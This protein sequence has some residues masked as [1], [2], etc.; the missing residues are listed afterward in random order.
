MFP[1]L[2]PSILQHRGEGEKM[3]TQGDEMTCP[4]LSIRTL[5]K[6]QVLHAHGIEQTF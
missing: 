3:K 4:E 2:H 5:N 1:K 6:A